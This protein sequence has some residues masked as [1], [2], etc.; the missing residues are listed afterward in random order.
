M[1]DKFLY[2]PVTIGEE[3]YFLASPGHAMPVDEKV[4]VCTDELVFPVGF[5]RTG[6]ENVSNMACENVVQEQKRICKPLK[7]EFA[8][9]PQG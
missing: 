1:S 5:C 2:P 3:T 8:M 6:S 9:R 7:M 4:Y